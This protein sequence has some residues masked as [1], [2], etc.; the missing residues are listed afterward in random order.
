MDGG[1]EFEEEREGSRD[2]RTGSQGRGRKE[3]KGS[4]GGAW[5]GANDKGEDRRWRERLRS[6]EEKGDRR[7][8]RKT[9]GHSEEESREGG[10]ESTNERGTGRHGRSVTNRFLKKALSLFALISP[11]RLMAWMVV[12]TSSRSYRTGTFR[13]F[14]NSNVESYIEPTTEQTQTKRTKKPVMCFVSLWASKQEVALE[15]AKGTESKRKEQG[16]G[17]R[18][19]VISLP[20]AF[21]K[22]L[23]HR[24]FRGFRFILGNITSDAKANQAKDQF[25]FNKA[26][27]GE[28]LRWSEQARQERARGVK[29]EC[30]LE[31]LMTSR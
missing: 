30:V 21:R 10:K 13:R 7:K 28:N 18:T 23:V 2:S 6:R 29:R 3:G 22:D 8:G 16:K 1:G 11:T 31:V 20:A 27:L 14:W 15:K 24:T 26:S 12:W 25:G 9:E 17:E 5:E 19:I 4:R